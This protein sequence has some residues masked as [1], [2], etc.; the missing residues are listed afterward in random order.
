MSTILRTSLSFGMLLLVQAFVPTGGADILPSAIPGTIQAAEPAKDLVLELAKGVPLTAILIPAGTF[1]M[2]APF[3]ETNQG[4]RHALTNEGPQH[5]VTI[6]RAFYLGIYPVTQ[7]QY[8]AVMGAI[9]HRSDAK[10][11]DEV[12]VPGA[13]LPVHPFVYEDITAFCRTLSASSGRT[14]RLTTEA[15]WE[16]ACRAGTTTAWFWGDDIALASD[17]CWPAA[18]K[19]ESPTHPVGQKKPNPW[20]LYDMVGHI[21][22]VCSD[23]GGH[24]PRPAEADYPAGP[25]S[26]PTGPA[27]GVL[28]I[29]RGQ[30]GLLGNCRSAGYRAA[31]ARPDW[32]FRH[33][34]TFRVVIELPRQ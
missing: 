19:G 18:A 27:E 2:G 10:P 13:D 11:G 6:S 23:W 7:A 1:T 8:A 16:Y 30:S 28:H 5:P 21:T 20:G 22:Q 4:L 12:P 15:E 9:P 26:D 24:Y 14:V 25:V 34:F 32:V 17:Y 29:A 31:F 33:P 3:N